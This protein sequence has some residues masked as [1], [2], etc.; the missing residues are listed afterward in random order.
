MYLVSEKCDWP[1]TLSDGSYQVCSYDFRGD[2]AYVVRVLYEPDWDLYESASSD[3]TVLWR[4]CTPAI[5]EVPGGLTTEV[6]D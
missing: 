1:R 2:G 5:R 4:I 3:F 6:C